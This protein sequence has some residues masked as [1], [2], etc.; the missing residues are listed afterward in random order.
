MNRLALDAREVD[1]VVKGAN[2]AVIAVGYC[3]LTPE[4]REQE[5]RTLAAS[6][7]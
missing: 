4:Q 1:R 6:S 2:N 7:T 3:Q 5:V